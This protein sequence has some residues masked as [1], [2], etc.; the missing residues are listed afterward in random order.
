VI[1]RTCSA[2]GV[3]VSCGV[4]ISRLITD[5]YTSV[6]VQVVIGARAFANENRLAA[7]PG[8]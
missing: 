1:K 8:L 6:I 2:G 5:K 4:G 3:I 7:V